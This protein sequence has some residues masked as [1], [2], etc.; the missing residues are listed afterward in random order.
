M[1]SNIE[2]YNGA[3]SSVSGIPNTL[4]ECSFMIIDCI[5]VAVIPVTPINAIYLQY[6]THKNL[7]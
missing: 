1:T 3:V 5:V 4:S 2:R 7:K 6:F